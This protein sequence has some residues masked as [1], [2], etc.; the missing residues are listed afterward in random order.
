MCY[1]LFD[2]MPLTDWLILEVGS[3]VFGA[4]EAAAVGRVLLGFLLKIAILY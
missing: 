1:Y 3:C 4:F 2:C